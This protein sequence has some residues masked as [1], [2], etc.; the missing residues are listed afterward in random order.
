MDV[1]WYCSHHHNA[2]EEYLPY[3][4]SILFAYRIDLPAGAKTIRLPN[5]HNVRVLAISV[6]D[7]NPKCSTGC[8][9]YAVDPGQKGRAR[10]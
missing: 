4:Y 8:D 3:A 7:E 5:S 6:A 10:A 2:A 9:A 1:A